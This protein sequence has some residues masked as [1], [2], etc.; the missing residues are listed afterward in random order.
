MANYNHQEAAGQL[1]LNHLSNCAPD[2]IS[3]VAHKNIQESVKM[4]I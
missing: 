1:L 2:L 4:Y 3:P